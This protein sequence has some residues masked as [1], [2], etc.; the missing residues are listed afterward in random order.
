MWVFVIFGAKFVALCHRGVGEDLRDYQEGWR[1]R[2]EITDT[3]LLYG[4]DFPPGFIVA[5][6]L[7]LF[8]VDNFEV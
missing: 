6:V 7:V 2:G 1:K 8:C 3:W 5:D 4:P